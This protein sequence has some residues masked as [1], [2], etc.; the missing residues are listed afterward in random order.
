MSQI[1]LFDTEIV[2]VSLNRLAQF[3]GAPNYKVDSAWEQIRAWGKMGESQLTITHFL[4]GYEDWTIEFMIFNSSTSYRKN[5]YHV[6]LEVAQGW[7]EANADFII[8][9]MS[10]EI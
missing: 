5:C 8:E 4:E 10:H 9:N 1:K 2:N 6:S 3:L 7:L